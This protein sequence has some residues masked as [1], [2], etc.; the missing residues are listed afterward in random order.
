MDT[1]KPKWH[2]ALSVAMIACGGILLLLTVLDQDSVGTTDYA[3]GGGLLVAG[4]WNLWTGVRN[5]RMR[6]PGPDDVVRDS[7]DGE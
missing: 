3:I 6:E 1:R 4:V 2:V 7:G 5:L